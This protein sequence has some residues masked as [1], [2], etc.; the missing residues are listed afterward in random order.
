MTKMIDSH[1]AIYL[2]R[3]TGTIQSRTDFI[4]QDTTLLM[5]RHLVG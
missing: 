5:L 3:F 1:L 4:S 2:T